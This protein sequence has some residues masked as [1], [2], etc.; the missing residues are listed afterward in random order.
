MTNTSRASR[1]VRR[2][3]FQF[4]D[5]LMSSLFAL[6]ISAWLSVTYS[7]DKACHV[8]YIDA[9]ANPSA[10]MLAWR[11]ADRLASGFDC[12]N[13]P[14]GVGD[15]SAA[16][17]YLESAMGCVRPD[18][19]TLRPDDAEQQGGAATSS[20][21]LG[22]EAEDDTSVLLLSLRTGESY[23]SLL[24][25]RAPSVPSG[26]GAE[27]GADI[28]PIEGMIVSPQPQGLMRLQTLTVRLPRGCTGEGCR[29]TSRD[30][31]AARWGQKLIPGNAHQAI[32]QEMEAAMQRGGTDSRYRRETLVLTVAEGIVC[33]HTRARWESGAP[34]PTHIDRR[35]CVPLTTGRL[36]P[37][38]NPLPPEYLLSEAQL[39]QARERIKDRYSSGKFEDELSPQALQAVGDLDLSGMRLLLDHQ[40][41]A[42]YA[43]VLAD[44]SA[45]Y[46]LSATYDL[47]VNVPAGLAPQ[48]A[49]QTGAAAGKS[50][51][52]TD[53]SA[54]HTFTSPDQA[55]QV[56]LGAERLRLI[57]PSSGT[58]ILH[59]ELA[60]DDVVSAAWIS[61]AQA[62]RLRQ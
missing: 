37:T 54:R 5:R 15:R 35:G 22:Q 60:W 12:S 45:P 19:Q 31:Y 46:A 38:E 43:F 2:W 57:D 39:E 47:Q 61:G 58:V 41:G 26:Q 7:A 11:A 20:S 51:E 49:A 1:L 13:E 59:R 32:R 10:N 3:A 34:H 14:L 36:R 50:D 25:S 24:L 55:L 30:V 56:V 27:Q 62:Q 33:G 48:P 42:L 44:A 29:G 40:V 6:A 28:F 23:R 21:A 52:R 16:V 53:A 4:P 17:W 9:R 8:A 18:S